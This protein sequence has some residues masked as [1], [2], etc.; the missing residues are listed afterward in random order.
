MSGEPANLA[1][2]GKRLGGILIDAGVLLVILV[3][4]ALF[5]VGLRALFGRDAVSPGRRLLLECVAA[6]VWFV[7]NGPLLA[8]KGQTIGKKAVGTRIV[9]LQGGLPP[10]SHLLALRYI[11]PW[12]VGA[13][14]FLGGLFSLA[15]ALLVFGPERRC[16][17]DYLAGTRVVNA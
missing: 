11:V 3:P 17:H 9:D 16:I 12:L 13:V 7:L 8:T 15:D 2:R 6:A 4:I 5:S 1:S 14:P 10:L